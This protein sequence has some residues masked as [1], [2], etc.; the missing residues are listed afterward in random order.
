MS[1]PS[2]LEQL[3][4]VKQPYYDFELAKICMRLKTYGY[5]AHVNLKG[6][7]ILRKKYE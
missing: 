1:L 3:N 4:E 7:L 6:E 5:T 2:L